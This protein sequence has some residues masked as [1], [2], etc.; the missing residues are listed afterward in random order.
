MNELKPLITIIIPVYNVEKYLPTC[1]ESVQAQTY[2]NWE[3]ILVD[4]G[5]PDKSGEICD[6]YARGD[7]RLTVLH[8]QNGGLS[9]ARNRALDCPPKGDFVTFLDSDDFWHKDYLT[10]LMSLQRAFNADMVQCDFIRGAEAVFPNLPANVRIN[11]FDNHSIFVS[12]KANVIM[13]GKIYRTSLFDGIRMPEGLYNEDDWTAWK[14]YYKSK[15]IVVT[16]QKLYYYTVNPNS[17]M[18]LLG[19]KPDLRYVNAYNERIGF[20]VET[21]E[22]DLEHSSRLQLCKSLLLTYRHSKFSKDERRAVKKTF[23]ENWKELKHSPYIKGWYKWLFISF[24]F[25]P[26]LISVF[27]N[28]IHDK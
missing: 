4:D 1:I 21:G 5:S 6:E 9:R 20:F 16:S 7:S 10:N 25:T 12:E 27:A 23:D 17:T 24:E 11:E 28:K 18:A 8:C 22:K 14:L 3:M 26:M 13:C 2:A 15:S 19:K